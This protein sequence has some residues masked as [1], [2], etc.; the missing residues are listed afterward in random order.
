ML[1]HP[2]IVQPMENLCLQALTESIPFGIIGHMFILSILQ[3][4]RDQHCFTEQ[5]KNHGQPFSDP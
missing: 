5:N 1:Y 2:S 3:H 4:G